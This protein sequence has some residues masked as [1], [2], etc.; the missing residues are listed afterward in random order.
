MKT[1]KRGRGKSSRNQKA[2]SPLDHAEVIDKKFLFTLLDASGPSGDETPVRNFIMKHMKQYGAQIHVDK[3]GNLICR[4]KGKGPSIMLAAHMDEIG[5]MVKKIK[6]NGNLIPTAV[7]GL[8]PITLL[9]EHVSLKT[10]QGMITGVI[11]TKEIEDGEEIKQLPDMDDLIVDTGLD[12]ETL[13]SLGVNIGDYFHVLTKATTLGAPNVISGK[14]LDDRLGCFVLLT[15]AK[16]LAK[17]KL[18]ADVYYVFTVQEEVGL[19][20]ART[21][22][23]SLDPDMALVVEITNADEFA[24][25]K[26]T[27]R[28]GGGP[29]ITVK[30][31]DMIGNKK[32]NDLLREVAQKLNIPLQAEVSDFGTTDA[33]SISVSKGGIPTGVLSVPIRNIHT[34][35]GIAH[36]TDIGA[37]IKMVEYLLVNAP[38]LCSARPGKGKICV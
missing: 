35:A 4:K 20:G 25:D 24:R 37:T 19:Y 26:G 15:V 17:V 3:F 23:Y 22:V 10:K 29:C 9:G 11:T 7:G 6:E 18:P 30:D 36:L 34:T 14:A 28:I 32:I 12:R 16:H 2:I 38:R 5:V 8:E 33:L 31:A 1:G 27:K 13:I 21:S